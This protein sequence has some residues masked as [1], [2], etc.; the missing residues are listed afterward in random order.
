LSLSF[1]QTA[2]GNKPAWQKKKKIAARI[3][4]SP[5]MFPERKLN[6]TFFCD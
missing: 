1:I 2:D 5:G 3:L 4:K 6:F